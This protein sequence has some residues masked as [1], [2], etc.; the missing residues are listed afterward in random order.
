MKYIAE[1]VPYTAQGEKVVMRVE[2][3]IGQLKKAV[4]ECIQADQDVELVEVMRLSHGYVHLLRTLD[5]VSDEDT[6]EKASV[7]HLSCI[8][9]L[10]RDSV[11]P[12]WKLV[13]QDCEPIVV[14]VRVG[15]TDFQ[16]PVNKSW[17][18]AD[19]RKAIAIALSRSEDSITIN[20]HGQKSQLEMLTSWDS[21]LSD[22]KWYHLMSIICLEPA[23][24]ATTS[25]PAAPLTPAVSTAPETT[26]AQVSVLVYDEEDQETVVQ[27]F[28][29]LKWKLA[30]LVTDLKKLFN[31]DLPV[32][33]RLKKLAENQYFSQDHLQKRLSEL[34]F[35][36]GGLRVCFERG[37]APKAGEIVL[38]VGFGD[39]EFDL[40]V[41][42][43]ATV[44]Q[45]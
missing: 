19:A 12:A 25:V 39:A 35:A 27:H 3:T 9:V 8:V 33:C 23:T 7:K 37:P 28:V 4:A 45:M 36:E 5:S 13:G 43:N 10:P 21:H 32:E 26:P 30:K 40:F 6:L 14:N 11:H 24:A 2:E 16:V 41:P 20:V 18:L 15:K 31:V 29:P 38:K 42:G 1:T 17:T 34:G 22:L 44:G